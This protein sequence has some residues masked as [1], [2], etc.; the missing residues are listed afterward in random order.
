MIANF[1]QRLELSDPVHKAFAYGRPFVLVSVL[2]NIFAMA[3]TD[4]ILWQKIVTVRVGRFSERRRVTRI[5]VEHKRK[6]LHCSQHF[7]RLFARA[8]VTGSFVF[9]YERNPLFA[10]LLRSPTQLLVHFRPIRFR[11]IQS[12]EIKAA[13]PVGSKSLREFD[14]LVEYLILLIES[15]VRIELVLLWAEFRFRRSR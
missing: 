4:P 14:A 12:P 1:L 5:P 6:R 15:E 9:K 3:V 10:R 13:H 11:I 2:D 7:C 8:R